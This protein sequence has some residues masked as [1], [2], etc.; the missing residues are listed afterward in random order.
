[1]SMSQSPG[2]Q[3]SSPLGLHNDGNCNLFIAGLP[4]GTHD[5]RLREV[6]APFGPI[7][8]AKVMVDLKTKQLR[9]HGFVR[10]ANADSAALAVTSMHRRK[11][12]DAHPPIHVAYATHTDQDRST[13]CEVVYIRN[14]P[15]TVSVEHLRQAFSIYGTVLD[16]TLPVFNNNGHQGVGFVRFQTVDEAREAVTKAHNTCPFGGDKAIQVRFKESKTTMNVRRSVAGK[17]ASPNGTLHYSNPASGTSSPAPGMRSHAAS[18]INDSLVGSP[19]NFSLTGIPPVPAL[20][21]LTPQMM[22]LP[23][24]SS[25]PP[26]YQ[27]QSSPRVAPVPVAP[28]IPALPSARPFPGANDL[29]FTNFVSAEWLV[30]EVLRPWD[31]VIFQPLM[32]GIVVRLRDEALHLTAA[33]HLGGLLNPTGSGFLTV[34]LLHM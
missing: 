9:S 8:S 19:H 31:P 26:I 1:M 5:E 22:L 34:A 4:P 28:P 12:D 27:L 25:S 30:N 23:V 33:Q 15:D 10:Y 16:V 11:M 13:E 24:Q 14:L 2:P 17:S 32:D 29:Y 18:P 21:A 7:I 20:P 3:S 6:F